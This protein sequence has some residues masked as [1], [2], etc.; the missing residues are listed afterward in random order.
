MQLNI[1]DTE[2][3]ELARALARRGGKSVTATIKEALQDK[4]DAEAR[5]MAER[6]GRIELLL[7]DIHA[8]L[9]VPVRSGSAREIMDS[10]YDDDEADGFAR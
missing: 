9:P 2:T 4:A 6:R 1:K 10:I 3:I 7:A 5:A 8:R